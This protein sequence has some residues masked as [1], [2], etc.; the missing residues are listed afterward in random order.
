MMLFLNK[1][2]QKISCLLHHN[3]QAGK[4]PSLRRSQVFVKGSGSGC[5]ELPKKLLPLIFREKGK[6]PENL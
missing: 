2:F 1:G 4:I 5:D 3:T 6:G